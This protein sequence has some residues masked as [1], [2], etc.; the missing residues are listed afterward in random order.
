M[1]YL[2]SIFWRKCLLQN[3][4]WIPTILFFPILYFLGWLIVQPFALIFTNIN[5]EYISLLGTLITFFVFLLLLPSWIKIR[6][7]ETNPLKALGLFEI[8][9]ERTLF[10]IIRGL[11]F[12]FFL[13]GILL[14]TLFCGGWVQTISSITLGH[15]LNA[16]FLGIIVG[17]A[18]EVVFR[19]WLLGEM[20][21]LFNKPF[22]L[23]M[24]ALVF[25]LAHIRINMNLIDSLPLFFGLFLL[26]ILLGTRKNLDGGS[27]L[28]SISLH[29]GLVG[30]WFLIDNGLIVF[31]PNT[32]TLLIGPGGLHP[33]PI[34]GLGAI[35]SMTV[36]LLSQRKLL[37]R[38]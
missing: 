35:I 12:A 18:E 37:T 6:W 15:F 23:F 11:F 21:F 22:G 2:I 5:Y 33:N 25:S 20:N 27:L 31:S 38:F 19:G 16:I 3:R 24:Q 4:R 9:I 10:Y 28:G 1:I 29:G 30:V 32:P 13:I 34:G 8:S 26:G 14:I 7:K 17:F 36:I